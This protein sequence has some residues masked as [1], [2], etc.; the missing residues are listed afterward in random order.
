[1]KD[2]MNAG[3]RLEKSLVV[4]RVIKSAHSIGSRFLKK[5]TDNDEIP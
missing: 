5:E 4:Y 2:Y 3:D 1:M